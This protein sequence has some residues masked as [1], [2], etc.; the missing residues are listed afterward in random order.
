MSVLHVGE[1]ARICG[2]STCTVNRW[3]DQGSLKATLKEG[4]G[5]HGRYD[6]DSNEFLQFLYSNNYKGHP[7]NISG[8]MFIR[9]PMVEECYPANLLAAVLGEQL[10]P[11]DDSYGLN[12]WEYDIGAFRKM[13]AELPERNQR[14]IEL[15]YKYGMTLDEIGAAFGRTRER[16]RMISA[17]SERR[18]RARIRQE[19]MRCVPEAKYRELQQMYDDLKAQYKTLQ[20]VVSAK[21]DSSIQE[22]PEDDML[23]GIEVLNLSTRSYNSLKFCGMDTIGDLLTFDANQGNPEYRYPTWEKIRNLGLRSR[24]EVA[25]ALYNYCGMRIHHYDE[26]NQVY[27]GVIPITTEESVSEGV[28]IRDGA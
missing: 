24:L 1:I 16:I 28:D 3:I 14:V 25:T 11:E 19:G 12:V 23:R 7:E 27:T 21:E 5:R 4:Y 6:I 9:R 10:E 20:A 17:Q 13:I 2:V 26:Q 15:R 22:I 8:T 18:L